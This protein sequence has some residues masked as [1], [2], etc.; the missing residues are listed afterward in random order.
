[1]NQSIKS[2]P[3]PSRLFPSRPRFHLP[4]YL[5]LFK[6]SPKAILIGGSFSGSDL[7]D[8]GPSLFK[9]L[10]E[11]GVEQEY[12][13]IFS[14]REYFDWREHVNTYPSKRSVEIVLA[15]VCRLD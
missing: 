4:R 8:V 12:I 10:A 11:L 14:D 9:V 1:M 13:N 7:Q 2:V 15:D 3:V 5:F 6:V